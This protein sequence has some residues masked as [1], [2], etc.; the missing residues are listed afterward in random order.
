MWVTVWRH[1]EA[2]VAR[3]DEDRCL[4][5]RGE[6]SVTRAATAFRESLIRAG[7]VMPS[8]CAYSPLQRTRQTAWILGE[9]WDVEPRVCEALAPGTAV[10]RPMDFLSDGLAHQVIVS[11]QPFVSQLIWYWLD[12]DG[13]DPL[14]PGGWATI[15][16]T[17]P[18]RGG[19][20]LVRSR[21]NIFS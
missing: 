19:G 17:A 4:T 2:G 5:D 6:A 21:A 3:R 16:L 18:A 15:E 8:S 20:R 13:L 1:G 12:S 7:E 9:I 14:E 11:H 10:D